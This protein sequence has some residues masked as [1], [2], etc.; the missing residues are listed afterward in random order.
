MTSATGLAAIVTGAALLAVMLNTAD[1]PPC[2]MVQLLPGPLYIQATT[3][4][5]FS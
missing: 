2:P 5:C 3:H 1:P 4:A